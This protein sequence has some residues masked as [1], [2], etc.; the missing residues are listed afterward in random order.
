MQYSLIWAIGAV[1]T[2][3]AKTK[4]DVADTGAAFTGETTPGNSSPVIATI[5]PPPQKSEVSAALPETSTATS[6][7]D[8]KNTKVATLGTDDLKEYADQPDKVKRLIARGLALTQMNLNYKY[9]SADPK[10]GGMDCSGTVYYLLREAGL[11]DVP[12]D[13]SGLYS[14]LWKEKRFRA[15]VSQNPDSFEFSELKPGDLLFWTGTYR[16]DHDPPVTHV[17]IYL[18]RNRQ[19]GRRV[20]LGASEGRPFDGKSRYGVSVFDF[21]MPGT[22]SREELSGVTA[23]EAK[24]ESR[25]IG[26]GTIPGFDEVAPPVATTHLDI[27]PFVTKG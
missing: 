3:M 19:T 10:N 21:K 5:P 24:L 18:G 26:Y 2:G 17:M 15:V 16:V 8:N 25:F 22:A 27:I 11:G 12:R 9:G 23:T 7:S 1:G 14:W 13:A 20:M 4:T 6:A